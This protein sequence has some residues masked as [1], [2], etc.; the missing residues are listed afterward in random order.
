SN[1]AVEVQ[2]I[3]QNETKKSVLVAS[4]WSPLTAIKYGVSVNKKDPKEPI[5][6]KI[7]QSQLDTLGLKLVTGS[8]RRLRKLYVT[9]ART[10]LNY[11]AIVNSIGRAWSQ[12]NSGFRDVSTTV[13]IY[14]GSNRQKRSPTLSSEYSLVGNNRE[15]LTPLQYTFAVDNREPNPA[16]V[17]EPSA[18]VFDRNLA[19]ANTATCGCTPRAQ[20]HVT[21]LGKTSTTGKAAIEDAIATAV[22]TENPSIAKSD[23]TVGIVSMTD[24]QDNG[25]QI[26]TVV[27]LVECARDPCDVEELRAPSKAVLEAELA[28]AGQTLYSRA[29]PVEEEKNK[30]L[31]PVA[32]GCGVALFIII[33]AIVCCCIY[34]RRHRD[35]WRVRRSPKVNSSPTR[36]RKKGDFQAQEQDIKHNNAYDKEH[37]SDA[38]VYDNSGLQEDGHFKEKL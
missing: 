31:I 9:G 30:W 13:V 5:P 6:H 38:A 25:K 17:E 10:Q 7:L 23:I 14:H 29:E 24:G 20:G 26:S 3:S 34:R 2:I 12:E 21:L 22:A 28:Q 32:V 15:V 19:S 11:T 36:H 8:V 4:D 37:F 16:L 18:D 1:N 27:Y 35:M 33:M